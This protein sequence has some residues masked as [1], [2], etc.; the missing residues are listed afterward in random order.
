MNWLQKASIRFSMPGEEQ[1]AEEQGPKFELGRTVMTPGAQQAMVQAGE[2]PATFLRRHQHG[3]WGDMSAED[4]QENEFSLQNGFRLMSSYMLQDGTKI[5]VITE[6]D[7]SVTTI[8][9]PE[10]Y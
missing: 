8:L 2:N 5:W 6:A 10:E 3:D 1:P 7:R 4:V 9:L